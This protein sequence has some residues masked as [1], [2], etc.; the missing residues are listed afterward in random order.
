M[1][2]RKIINIALISILLSSVAIGAE[3][4][5][6]SGGVCFVPL[7]NS[8]VTKKIKHCSGGVCIVPLFDSKLSKSFEEQVES[9]PIEFIEQES[10]GIN[11][12]SDIG[13]E[14]RIVSIETYTVDE[15]ES[16]DSL[17]IA[18]PVEETDN[19]ILEKTDLPRS[20]Y[21]C[22]ND[23]QPIYLSN[24]TYECV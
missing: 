1:K 19:K 16:E 22:E 13:K 7:V 14:N 17:L 20:D 24:D 6:C 10:L 9:Q 3:D 21:F 4:S 2:N 18:N 12:I 8:K 23:K 5:D 15:E 11:N